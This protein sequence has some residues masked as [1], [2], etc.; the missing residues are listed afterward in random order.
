MRSA[1]KD[2]ATHYPQDRHELEAKRRKLHEPVP[3]CHS[4]GHVL[5]ES[6]PGLK[7]VYNRTGMLTPELDM[8]MLEV[9]PTLMNNQADS[10]PED[11]AMDTDECTCG[12]MHG[13]GQGQHHD[14]SAVG[15]AEVP[16]LRGPD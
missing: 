7:N 5:P 2:M 1:N 14:H 10:K 6:V 13:P 9:S 16:L 12:H 8:P 4:Y 3:L 11:D 15:L